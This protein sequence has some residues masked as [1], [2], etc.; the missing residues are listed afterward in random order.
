MTN[1]DLWKFG[2]GWLCGYTEDK[3]L[4]RRVK[5]YKKDW[6]ILADYFK[7]DRLI[8]VQFKIPIEQRHAAGGF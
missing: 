7:N 1:N 5:R 6:V 4:I 3:E 8:G 2:K